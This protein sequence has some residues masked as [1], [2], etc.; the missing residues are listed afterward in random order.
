MSRLANIEDEKR[1][2]KRAARWEA[3]MTKLR[4]RKKDRLLE[5]QFC[6]KYGINPEVFNRCKRGENIPSQDTFD[7]AE[8]GF[9]A[10]R[11]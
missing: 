3:R 9:S 4:N 5:S 7:K 1:R 6:R 10:E 8:A 11:V 2:A